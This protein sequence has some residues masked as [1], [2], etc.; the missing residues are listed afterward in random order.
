MADIEVN[1]AG[2]C[3]WVYPDN[4]TE[5][6]LQSISTGTIPAAVSSG[7]VVLDSAEEAEVTLTRDLE[8]QEIATLRRGAVD[9][10][11]KKNS[12]KLKINVTGIRDT[13]TD[14]IG[15][16]IKLLQ[17]LLPGEADGD[18]L[19]GKNLAGESMRDNA[20]CVFVQKIDAQNKLSDTPVYTKD[21]SIF[22]L[23]VNDSGFDEVFSGE[24]KGLEIE[25]KCL[26]DGEGHAYYRQNSWTVA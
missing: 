13:G 3:L 5:T 21:L 2:A 18:T 23:C 14:K 10:K 12:Y 9:N 22:P 1:I 6:E 15:N 19:K 24:N 17:T 7:L 11:I 16:T 20:V 25:Y 8:L 26:F 4:L